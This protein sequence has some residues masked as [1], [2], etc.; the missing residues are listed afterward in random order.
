MALPLP[1]ELTEAL[2]GFPTGQLYAHTIIEGNVEWGA[3]AAGTGKAD[4]HDY[5]EIAVS[6]E[7]P[8]ISSRLIFNG[9]A[10]VGEHEATSSRTRALASGLVRRPRRNSNSPSRTARRAPPTTR[11]RSGRPAANSCS[12]PSIRADP[13]RRDDGPPDGI[14]TSVTIPH[15]IEGEEVDTSQVREARIHT[16]RRHDTEPVRSKRPGSLQTEPGARNRRHRSVHR[17]LGVA[18]P[19]GSKIGTVT[20]EVPTL[21]NGS[22]TGRGLPRRTGG[23][24]RSPGRRSRCTSSRTPKSYGVSVRLEARSDPG[25]EH[26]AG[27]DDVQQPARTAVQQPEDQLRTGTCS[28]R[29][30]TRCSCGEA[31]GA[32]AFESPFSAPLQRREDRTRSARRST[33]CVSSPPP[34]NPGQST[35]NSNG[36]AGATHELHAEPRP[37]RRRPVHLRRSRRSCLRASSARSRSPNAAGEARRVTAKPSRARRPARSARRRCSRAPVASRSR[38]PG[39]VYL[40]GPDEGARTACRSRFRRSPDPSTSARS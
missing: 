29:S 27:D 12:S 21:P 14:S 18:C 15:Q 11:P 24:L 40:T 31:K 32:A 19:A 4:Y 10:G 2:L 8:L 5:F 34:F 3:Q 39:P 23:W 20:L 22:L 37:Q 26:G 33:G 28:R 16:A 17:N 1:E 35:V 25:P 7:L 9:R 13:E 30:R 6:P 38:S 36:N